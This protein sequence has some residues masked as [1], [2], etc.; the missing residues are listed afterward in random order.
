MLAKCANPSC[1]ASLRYL[2]EGR[3][4]R[5]EADPALAP[6]VD[7]FSASG[8]RDKTEYFWLCSRCSK[9][10]T[11]RLDVDGTVI[12]GALPNYGHHNPEDFAVISRHGGK[13][14][15]SISFDRIRRKA[16]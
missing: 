12:I 1:S 5:L 6:S 14:L 11:L 8:G 15:M 2:L 13:L 16:D 9:T 4:F 10:V 3:L 7:S